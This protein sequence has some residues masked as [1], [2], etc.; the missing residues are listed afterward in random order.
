MSHFTPGPWELSVSNRPEGVHYIID[1]SSQNAQIADVTY[2]CTAEWTR[3]NALLIANAPRLYNALENLIAALPATELAW[4]KEFDE[5]M[6]AVMAAN[7]ITAQ[8]TS[9]V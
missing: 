4:R 3:A 8:S 6:Y 1:E 2:C 9:L 5:A 7:G